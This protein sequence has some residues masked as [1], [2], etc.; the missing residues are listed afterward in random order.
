MSS[1]IRVRPLS[2]ADRPAWDGLWAGY[3]AFYESAL[4]PTVSQTTWARLLDAAFPIHGLVAVDEADAPVGLTHYVLHP[5][6][7]AVGPYCYLEDLFVDPDARAGGVG[8]ALI[9]AVYAAADAAGAARVYWLTHET[10]A[11]ARVLY[12]RVAKAS[13]FIQYRR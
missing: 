1:S 2:V 6:T 10:N 3:L 7:W 8:R 12:D 4:D 11:G 13:G 9:E 5:A